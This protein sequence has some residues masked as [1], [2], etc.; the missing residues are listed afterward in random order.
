MTNDP[1]W[2]NSTPVTIPGATQPGIVVGHFYAGDLLY[3]RVAIDEKATAHFVIPS[4]DLDTLTNPTT[5]RKEPRYVPKPRRH[6]RR[7]L[8]TD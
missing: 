4:S 8:G 5:M 6:L 1:I 2:P 7:T 3:Y